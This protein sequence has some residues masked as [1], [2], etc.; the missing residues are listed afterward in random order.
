M[1]AAPRVVFVSVLVAYVA[2][3]GTPA[4]TENAASITIDQCPS[5]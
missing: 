2:L 3:Q 4:R 5:N 1:T